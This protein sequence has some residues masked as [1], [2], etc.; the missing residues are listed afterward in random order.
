M[1]SELK[2]LP[3][4]TIDILHKPFPLEAFSAIESKTYLTTLKA[5]YIVERL[6][7]A[8]GIGRWVVNHSIME[9]TEDFV[10]IR[11]RMKLL[12]FPDL[13]FPVTYG[14]HTTVGK[15]TDIADGFK[16]AVTDLTSKQSSFLEIAL[17]LYKGKIKGNG[18]A[19]SGSNQSSTQANSDT[20]K[21]ISRDDF[22][23]FGKH[24]QG[25]SESARWKEVPKHYLEWLSTADKTREDVKIFVIQELKFRA[26]EGDRKPKKSIAD[27]IADFETVL[28]GA[29]T[30][31]RKAKL[32]ATFS[33]FLMNAFKTTD[34]PKIAV[35]FVEHAEEI[36][37]DLL[38]LLKQEKAALEAGQD[39]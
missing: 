29:E 7:E 5:I 14:G 27:K 6:N 18:I 31:F 32:I 3:P 10:L 25:G 39:D 16:S 2:L 1:S 11:G 30:E 13:H 38:N 20:Q 37:K 36:H 24:K 35:E 19:P 28:L 33:S 26:D 34:I 22:P 17:D 9:R 21:T 8:F 23:L 15:G 12:D 4:D